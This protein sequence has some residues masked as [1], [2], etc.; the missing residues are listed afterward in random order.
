M[1]LG[2][3]TAH[4]YLLV[5]A[6]FPFAPFTTM[7]NALVLGSSKALFILLRMSLKQSQGDQYQWRYESLNVCTWTLLIT[8]Q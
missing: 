6:K 3:V 4:F 5:T 8:H 1:Q 2:T 7:I